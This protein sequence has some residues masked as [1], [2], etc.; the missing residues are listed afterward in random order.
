MSGKGSSL[1]GKSSALSNVSNAS[2]IKDEEVPYFPDRKQDL[3]HRELEQYMEE[4]KVRD[5][6]AEMIAHLVENRSEDPIQ[7]ALDF[8]ENYNKNDSPKE[9]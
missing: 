5:I 1:G 2:S 6:L 4:H 3:D 8:I 7:G 9:E